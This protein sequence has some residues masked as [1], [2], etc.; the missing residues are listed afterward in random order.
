VNG[1]HVGC[2][3]GGHRSV[4]GIAEDNGVDLVG[5]VIVFLVGSWGAPECDAGGAISAGA[6]GGEMCMSGVTQGIEDRAER[7]DGDNDSE[8]DGCGAER[9][10][11][12]D[13]EAGSGEYGEIGGQVPPHEWVALGLSRCGPGW[14][15]S[16]EV[17]HTDSV[18]ALL[19]CGVSGIIQDDFELDHSRNQLALP[20]KRYRHPADSHR[21]KRYCNALHKSR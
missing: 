9:L 6:A 1:A 12:S 13:I 4:G 20:Q 14:R 7:T 10:A 18:D 2:A 21:R 3:A 17:G 19:K 5:I 11:A 15:R 16:G 8:Q